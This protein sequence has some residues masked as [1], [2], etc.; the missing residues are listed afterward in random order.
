VRFRA[1]VRSRNQVL[2]GH[3]YRKQV[4]GPSLG[5]EPWLLQWPERLQF[6]TLLR[7]RGR[8]PF[9]VIVAR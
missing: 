1:Q 4:R 6:Q 7:L 2:L 9:R 8:G 5:P 3:E